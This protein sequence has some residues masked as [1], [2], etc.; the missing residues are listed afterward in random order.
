MKDSKSDSVVRI[1]YLS[2][3]FFT[4][5]SPKD[6]FPVPVQGSSYSLGKVPHPRFEE[7]EVAKACQESER[8]K[9]KSATKETYAARENR[10]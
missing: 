5:F 7:F 9:E 3:F 6:R 2:W 4:V 10:L 1:L 8:V